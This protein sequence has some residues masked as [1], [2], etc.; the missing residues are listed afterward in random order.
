MKRSLEDALFCNSRIRT[1]G[2]SRMLPIIDKAY[3]TQAKAKQHLLVVFLVVISILALI[4]VLSVIIIYRQMRKLSITRKELSVANTELFTI[5]S[6]LKNVNTNLHESNLIKEEYIGR[7][8]DQCSVYID[9]L[10]NYRRLLNKKAT[11]AK[12]DDLLKTLKSDEFI[13]EELKQ[14]YKTFDSTFLHLFPS[15]VSD[16]KNLLEDD[17]YIQL[18]PGQLLNTEL[19]IYALTRLGINDG[20]KIAQ[21]LRC[22]ASTIYNCRYKIRNNAKNSREEF[23]EMIMQIG[24][25][26]ST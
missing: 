18:K 26:T 19:R 7:Y 4:L 25:F 24:S 2:I 17:E 20:T 1:V 22:S 9:K 16:F 12:I 8:M 6:Q 14:F 5:N 3:Q 11:A 15:F 13:D 23:E 10:D 21:F